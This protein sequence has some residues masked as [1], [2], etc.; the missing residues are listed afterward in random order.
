MLIILS[1]ATAA[2]GRRDELAAAAREVVAATR[3][4]QGCL[5]YTF[6]ADLDDPDRILGLELWA[7]Q[8]A[9]DAHMSHPHTEAFLAAV[10]D[11]VAGP[12]DMSVHEVIPWG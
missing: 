12:P 11:L 2:P 3:S 10:P 6:S 8:V 4:D 9:L 5:A 7:D 1:S